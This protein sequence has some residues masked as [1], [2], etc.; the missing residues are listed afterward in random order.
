MEIINTHPT[1][2][3]EIHKENKIFAVKLF[4]FE[5]YQETFYCRLKRDIKP[6]LK[7]LGYSLTYDYT[8]LKT[9]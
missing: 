6:Q 9:I 1:K 4:E 2:T 8:L 5:Q 3:A 7:K